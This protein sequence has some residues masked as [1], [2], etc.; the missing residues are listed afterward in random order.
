MP[1]PPW[2][3]LAVPSRFPRRRPWADILFHRRLAPRAL[4]V[5]LAVLGLNLVD[6]LVTLR[7]VSAGAEELNPVMAA[8]LARGPVTF[9]VGKHLLGATGVLGILAHD[10]GHGRA[11]WIALFWVLLPTY[12]LVAAYQ[13][14]LFFAI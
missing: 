10:H 5:A 14:A 2:D 13:L 9:V 1:P 4:A 7:H 11:G 6:A 12:L 8:L 3:V